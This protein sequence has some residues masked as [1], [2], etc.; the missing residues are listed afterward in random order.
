M[1]N[2]SVAEV[3]SAATTEWG[4]C[5]HDQYGATVGDGGRVVCGHNSRWPGWVGQI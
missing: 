5:E 4:A 3:A 1:H 2:N